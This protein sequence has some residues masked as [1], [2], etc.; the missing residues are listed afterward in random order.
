[1]IYLLLSETNFSP[2]P[3]ENKIKFF[4]PSPEI[5]SLGGVWIFSGMTQLQL[6]MTRNVSPNFSRELPELAKHFVMRTLF[7][8]QPLPETL[9]NAWV[10]K[11]Q[12]KYV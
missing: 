3:Q 9:V 4:S 12:Q 10:K 7:A 2:L 1:L 11:E 5:S 8:E 6:P